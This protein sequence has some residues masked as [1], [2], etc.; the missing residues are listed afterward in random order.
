[1][2]PIIAI[3][4]VLF[5]IVTS[6]YVYTTVC[7]LRRLEQMAD[8]STEGTV[9]S[10]ESPLS[11]TK[12][13]DA[14]QSPI[15]RQNAA[16]L[17]HRYNRTY[18]ICSNVR[19]RMEEFRRKGVLTRATETAVEK[20]LQVLEKRNELLKKR[21]DILVAYAEKSYAESLIRDLAPAEE[22]R[23]ALFAKENDK[24]MKS[25]DLPMLFK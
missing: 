12:Y 4:L 21:F 18:N 25:V 13:I 8:I 1:M 22:E 24:L 5:G 15:L 3:T 19:E 14:L 23:A 2:K 17:R 11:S 6:S 10:E 7:D 9:L 20:N 16:E